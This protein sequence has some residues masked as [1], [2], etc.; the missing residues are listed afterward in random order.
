[1]SVKDVMLRRRGKVEVET[2][3]I[4]ENVK[5]TAYVASI[6]A[7]IQSLGYSL[8]ED[9][10]RALETKEIE[11]LVEFNNWLVPEL[12]KS[13][14]ADVEYNP[15]YPNFPK[16]V[17]QM[18]ELELYMNAIMHYWN[19]DFHYVGFENVMP[20]IHTELEKRFPALD[21]NKKVKQ[22]D[23]GNEEDRF[24]VLDNLMKSSV[25]YSD[26]DKEDIKFPF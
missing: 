19:R 20:E 23:L 4:N 16:Q 12:E 26:Q 8:S 2:S 10:F 7:N 24:E 13:V 25:S 11:Y 14:G 6:N 3:Q 17:M 9:L 18:D 21:L 1:M 5:N 22:L 15:M